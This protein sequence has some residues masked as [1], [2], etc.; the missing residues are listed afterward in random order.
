MYQVEE[1]AWW[2]MNIPCNG[3]CLYPLWCSPKGAFWISGGLRL[4]SPRSCR[5]KHLGWPIYHG[6][7]ACNA[8]RSKIV[9]L[10]LLEWAF[11]AQQTSESIDIRTCSYLCLIDRKSDLIDY[12]LYHAS[13]SFA[14]S[15]RDNFNSRCIGDHARKY[16]LPLV[17]P[18]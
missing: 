12:Q 5:W 15:F 3:H 1:D 4:C 2:S 18:W 7:A 13:P 16:F 14:F 6:L 9:W 8:E 10:A 11:G 17:L